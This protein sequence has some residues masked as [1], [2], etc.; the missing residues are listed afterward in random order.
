M[1]VSHR[2]PKLG[3][4]WP[5]GA[6]NQLIIAAICTDE[7]RALA[8]IKSWLD[9]TDLDDATFAEH[10][11]LAAIT[12]RF[13][14][15]LKMHP[16]YA[17]LCGL[18]RLNWTR[19]L[20][21]MNA[22]KPVLEE[23]VA[24]GLRL[25]LLKGACRV[26]MDPSE[27][28]S[29][30]AYD[31]D[32]LLSA[33]N[34][35]AAFEILVGNDWKSTRGESVMGLRGRISSVRARNFKSGKFGDIDLH[36]FAYHIA[37]QSDGFDRALFEEAT[38]ATFYD[39]PVFVPSAEERLAIAIG[40]GGWDGHSH[41]DWLVDA[42]RIVT[43]EE[44]DWDKFSRIVSARRLKGASAIALSYMTREIGVPI[45]EDVQRNICGKSD[46]ASPSQVAAMFLA[47]D[48]EKLTV[49]Q[50]LVRSGIQNYERLRHSGRNKSLDTPMFRAVSRSV[51]TAE[52]HTALQ[53]QI[54]VPQTLGPGRWA[55]EIS[56]ALQA[57]KMRR[58]IEFELNSETRNLCH[59]Q[60]FHLRTSADQIVI[61][62]RGHIDL[63]DGDSALTLSALPGKLVEE[64]ADRAR[65][66]KYSALPF[67]VTAASISR[68]TKG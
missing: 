58:R 49:A 2:F 34:F 28:K 18:Q 25:I 7:A 55:F 9:Q 40:H 26:A 30:T 24:A 45:P 4:A 15:N 8:A 65:R 50:R 29:R 1:T 27:Q 57:P 35:V 56:V 23:M 12:T 32:L 16:E 63:K 47:K 41:S 46:L 39:L 14:D 64:G 19:S 6:R 38:P 17:R 11:L 67:A 54:E 52:S 53:H 13:D 31:L 43:L 36:Q 3:W 61:R 21:A 66:D 48:T 10:R 33:D 59:L 37:N 51:N 20:M 68:A 62:F 5:Q 60:G 42:A 22:A 44:V